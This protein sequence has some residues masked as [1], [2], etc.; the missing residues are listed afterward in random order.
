MAYSKVEKIAFDLAEP[1]AREKGCFIYDVE[2]VKEGGF[3]FLRIY[4]DAESGI[5]LDE[6]EEISRTLSGKL[7]E[8]D[9]IKQNYYLEVSSPG[10]ER[11]LKTEEHFRRYIGETIDIKLYKAMDG[12]K[13]LT[14]VLEGFEDQTMTVNCGGKEL[15]IPL[16]AASVVRLHFEF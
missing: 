5:S 6:C 1:I 4:A 15:K 3:W 13:Q 7:D 11:K 8:T 14:A 10:L 16:S 2:Y 9:P 12:A